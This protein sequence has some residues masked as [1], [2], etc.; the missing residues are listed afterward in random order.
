[1]AASSFPRYNHGEIIKQ[2]NILE[3]LKNP[4]SSD[5]E[6]DKLL[7]FLTNILEYIFFSIYHLS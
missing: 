5:A 7:Q 1:M 2:L 6:V 4:V 3:I